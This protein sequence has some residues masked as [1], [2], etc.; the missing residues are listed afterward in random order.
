MSFSSP[1]EELVC[2]LCISVMEIE[3][4]P[5]NL[6]VIII[7]IFY[8][9]WSLT[10]CFVLW[11]SMDTLPAFENKRSFPRQ[12]SLRQILAF[13]LH[14]KRMM[15]IL[16]RMYVLVGSLFFQVFLS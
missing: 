14:V 3:R 15:D 5:I 7:T 2:E 16:R 6:F 9:F 4:A 1:I 8:L 12:F 10:V 11:I 13:W